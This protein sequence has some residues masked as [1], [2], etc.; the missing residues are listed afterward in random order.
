M[1]PG[2]LDSENGNEEGR[3]EVTVTV[4]RVGKDLVSTQFDKAKEALISL[5]ESLLI[6]DLDG[7]NG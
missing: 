5:S 2:S 4:C 7:Y 1:R 3:K 6:E